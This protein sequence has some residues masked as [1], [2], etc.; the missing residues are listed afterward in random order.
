MPSLEVDSRSKLYRV[1]F[2]YAGREFKRS[3]RTKNGKLAHAALGRISETL[4]L[5]ETGRLDIPHGSDPATFILSDGKRH[6]AKPQKL[7]TLGELFAAFVEARTPGVKEKNTEATEDL[8]I[9]HLRRLLKN[10]TIASSLTLSDVQKYVDARLKET[11]YGRPISPETVQKE[12]ATFGVVWNWAERRDLLQGRPPTRG[13]DFP[14]RDEKPPFMTW[15]EIEFQIARYK[16]SDEEAAE[17]WECLYLTRGQVQEVLNYVQQNARCTFLYPFLI[18]IAHTGARLSEACRLEVGDIDLQNARVLIREKKRSRRKA[19]TFRRVELT[20]TLVGVLRR[21]LS[22]H[23]GGREAFRI[24]PHFACHGTDYKPLNKHKARDQ[25][26]LVLKNS[27]WNKI[28]GFHVFR[29]S[30]ASNLASG[31]VDQRIIDEFMGHQ[32]DEMRKRYR[33]LF[34]ETKQRAIMQI[35]P[36]EDSAA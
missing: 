9:R 10:R 1:R 12:V 34:P 16:L 22:T 25:L 32:T 36:D 19:I 13:L 29:H 5:L 21:W 2:R 31:G 27:K 24:Q 35:L 28:R 4:M 6:D 7:L 17:L 8:H 18:F 30:F 3:L 23:P 11:R 20:P 26:K 15:D 33:H 14:K